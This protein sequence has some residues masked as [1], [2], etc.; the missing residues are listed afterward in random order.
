MNID[1]QIISF[2][3]DRESKPYGSGSSIA[4]ATKGF[5]ELCRTHPLVPGK[6]FYRLQVTDPDGICF[7]R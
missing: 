6:P 5:L 3:S 2:S 7:E 1:V 4:E